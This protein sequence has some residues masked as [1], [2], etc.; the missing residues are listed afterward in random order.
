MG[1]GAPSS[2]DLFWTGT[3]F[4]P[5]VR[6]QPGSPDGACPDALQGVADA[7]AASFLAD[8]LGKARISDEPAFDAGTGCPESHLVSLLDQLHVSGEP[9]ADLES[10]GSIDPMLV[11][12]NTA[13]LDV[14][15]SDV[16]VFDD[17]LPRADSGDSTITE[18]LVIS[19][20]IASNENARDALQAVLQDLSVPIPAD[21]DAEALEA[22][23]LAL[24]AEG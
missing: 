13:S 22:R 3:L 23:R 1:P 24:V 14:F 17:P 2:G 20:G 11:D 7:C 18:V 15:P 21:A 9:T 10:V 8:L 5:S 12:S 19:H 6:S 16:I 4:L